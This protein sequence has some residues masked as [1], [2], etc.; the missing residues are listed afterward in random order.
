[1][2]PESTK[3][4]ATGYQVIRNA[5]LGGRLKFLFRDSV[6]YGGASAVNSLITLFTLPILT[7]VFATGEYGAVDAIT[8]L[9]SIFVVTIR[10][11]QD[12]A[13]ARFFYDTEDH[14]ERRNIV[15]ES[16]LVQMV[17]CLTIVVLLL[18]FADSVVTRIIAVP[19]YARAFRVLVITFPFVTIVFFCRNLLKWTF[20]R[21]QF[22]WLSLGSTALVV[23]LTLVMT[24]VFHR[25][26]V[27]V[28]LAQLLGMSASALAGLYF[29]RSYFVWPRTF[30]HGRQMLMFGWPY[31]IVAVATT[32]IPAVDRIFITNYLNLE[33][34]GVYAVGY[35]FAF[36]LMLPITAF[37]TAW[38]P[39]GLAIYKEANAHET[40]NRVLVYWVSAISLVAFALVAGA[41]PIIIVGAS[42][43]YAAGRVVVLPVVFGLV[44]ESTAWI[45]GIGL[46]LSKKTYFNALSYFI[47]LIV[48][49]L[50]IWL[51]I[52]PL[53]IVGVAYGMMA[54]RV[55]QALTY[56]S[57]AYRVYPLR[58]GLKT[59]L[60]VLGATFI[61]SSLAQAV[62]TSSLIYYVSLRLLLFLILVAIIWKGVITAGE[63]RS[64][65]RECK[66]VVSTFLTRSL[67]FSPRG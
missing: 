50:A 34:M 41:E 35:K 67:L 36:F 29:C 37:Q 20:A 24:V 15:S 61:V 46:D 33:A 54:G 12:S 42:A 30:R 38:A 18:I 52:R 7:R 51:T 43:R 62:S 47:G 11:G 31:M 22:I 19:Q 28:F 4:T 44:M 5:S 1:M 8:V 2:T 59:P 32:V 48:S 16:L 26:V 10:M 21:G 66:S 13:V 45:T 17:L 3:T 49:T 65:V 40:Y 53:G 6:L 39:F 55:A 25:G 58:F 60:A 27:G 23:L 63:R 9:G 64:I 57:F 56:S 14:E